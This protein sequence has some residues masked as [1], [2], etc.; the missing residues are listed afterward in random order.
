M[1]LKAHNQTQE[2]IKRKKMSSTVREKVGY[3]ASA[4]ADEHSDIGGA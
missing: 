2:N 3:V 1:R 4:G